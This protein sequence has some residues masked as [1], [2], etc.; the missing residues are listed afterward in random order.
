M[1]RVTGVVVATGLT[2]A[3]VVGCG[4]PSQD[5]MVGKLKSET[6]TLEQQNYTSTAMMTVQTDSS[7]QTYYIQTYYEG[8][9]QYRIDLGDSNKNVNQIIVKN[10]NGMY[11]VSPSLQKVFRFNGDWAQNQGHIYLYDQILQQVIASAGNKQSKMTQSDGSYTFEIPI[12]PAN[13]VVAKE[14]V[15]IDSKTLQPTKVVLY[16]KNNTAVVLVNF[17]SFKTGVKFQSA[18]F[19]PYKL[20]ANSAAKTAAG[21]PSEFG[22]ILPTTT[23]HD[24]LDVAE[25]VAQDN[26]LLRYTGAKG[27]TLSEFRPGAGADGLPAANLVDLYGVPALAT[28]AGK[29]QQLTWLRNG[30]EFSLTSGQLTGDQ[31]ATIA[32]STFG[33]IGK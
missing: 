11:I 1:R 27:F 4:A 32:I 12:T 23:F 21:A 17:T 18:N 15:Q 26:Y 19:D 30:V 8:P 13:D 2:L 14:T 20:A 16:D 10:P 31:L 24:K 28:T 25:P 3:M 5:A 6:Q 9:N 33:Q 29:T 7:S 22:Y